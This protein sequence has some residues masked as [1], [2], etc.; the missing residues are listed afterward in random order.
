MIIG[1]IK[2]NV[3]ICI[4]YILEVMNAEWIISKLWCSISTASSFA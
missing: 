1:K 4:A 2:H 3:D